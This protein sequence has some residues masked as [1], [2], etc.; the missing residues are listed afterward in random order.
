MELSSIIAIIISAAAF[1]T[2]V[3]GPCLSAYI[4]S[5]HEEKMYKK[6]FISEHEHEVIERYLKTAGKYSFSMDYNDMR[7]FGEA[8]AEIFMYAPRELWKDI[9]E[10]NTQ[11]SNIS[12]CNDFQTKKSKNKQLQKSYLD[13]CEKFSD[14]RRFS[15]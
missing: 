9:Q 3:I 10:L 1:L 2:S 5:K 11:I 15:K 8:S 12:L 14:F 4:Q 7:D 6:R 13:L